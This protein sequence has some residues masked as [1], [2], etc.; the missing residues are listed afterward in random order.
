MKNLILISILSL[1][2]SS[3]SKDSSTTLPANGQ[4]PLLPASI[5][6]FSNL[7]VGQ[8]YKSVGCAF[9]VDDNVYGKFYFI[10][11]DESSFSYELDTYSSASCDSQIIR[12]YRSH[13]KIDSYAMN[14]ETVD[15]SLTLT[16]AEMM[17]SYQNDVDSL[18]SSGLYL[19]TVI[20]V[21]IFQDVSGK[22]DNPA[23]GFQSKKNLS[24][25]NN[26]FIYNGL[27]FQ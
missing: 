9:L 1:V 5:P 2:L 10:K 7:T 23:L 14:N 21:S 8:L 19:P 3:C 4:N 18:N 15:L 27:T 26:S 16:L 6:I 24:L 17:V 12:S 11:L 22:N 13:Q 25:G 20:Q